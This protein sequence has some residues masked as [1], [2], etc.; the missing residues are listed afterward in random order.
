MNCDKKTQVEINGEKFVLPKKPRLFQ[1]GSKVHMLR[2]K[3]VLGIMFDMILNHGGLGDVYVGINPY[4]E[5]QQLYKKLAAADDKECIADDAEA[6]DFHFVYWFASIFCEYVWKQRNISFKDNFQKRFD[7]IIHTTLCYYMILG[8]KLF[9]I[10]GMPSGSFAT[11]TLNSIFNSF[12]TRAIWC[13]LQEIYAELRDVSF[14][15]AVRLGVF[16]DDGINTVLEQY[17][18][19]YN[20]KTTASL[21]KSLCNITKTPLEKDGKEV[22]LFVPLK[23]VGFEVGHGQF[24]KRTFSKENDLVMCPLDSESLEKML[25]WYVPSKSIPDRVLIG[26]IVDTAIVEYFYHGREK[27]DTMKTFI[28]NYMR[29]CV[30]PSYSH[31]NTYDDYM[32]AHVKNL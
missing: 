28:I 14:D 3:R 19:Y 9:M 17:K 24:L 21:W 22:P 16:G 29:K 26:Q 5:W 2:S 6:W 18:K 11:A 27:F 8:N 7:C 1:N 12:M 32:A 15:E 23:S 10:L 31:P 4:K 30:D 20:G 13:K 25:M